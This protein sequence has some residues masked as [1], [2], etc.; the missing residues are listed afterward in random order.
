MLLILGRLE[1]PGKGR[2]WRGE[3]PLR[4]KGEEKWDE[5]LWE[6]GQEGCYA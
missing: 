6:G 1:A 3:H 5:E 2:V 4:G